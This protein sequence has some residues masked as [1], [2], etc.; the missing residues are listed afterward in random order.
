MTGAMKFVGA[1]GAAQTW[2]RRPELGGRQLSL[3]VSE[4]WTVVPDAPFA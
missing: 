1:V 2:D 4:K 3:P